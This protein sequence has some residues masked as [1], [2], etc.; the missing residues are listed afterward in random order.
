MVT[1]MG[2][3]QKM[4]Q[5]AWTSGQGP[6][7]LGQ[8]M[9][10][11]SDCSGETADEIDA[12]VKDIVNRAYRWALLLHTRCHRSGH[13]SFASSWRF[14]GRWE[15]ARIWYVGSLAFGGPK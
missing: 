11:P 14:E 10:Q 8:Q 12:E 1:Q 3:S 6:S 13:G 9:G 5:V 7:F 2:F 4:G 15:T